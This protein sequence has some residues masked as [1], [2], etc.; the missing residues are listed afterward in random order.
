VL[1]LLLFL[2]LSLL[3]LLQLVQHV[4]PRSGLCDSVRDR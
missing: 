4:H 1:S 3:L 2:L